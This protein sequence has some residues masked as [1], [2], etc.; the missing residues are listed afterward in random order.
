MNQRERMNDGTELVSFKL[1]YD[2]VLFILLW[3]LFNGKL[4]VE[5]LAKIIMHEDRTILCQKLMN[6]ELD[7]M[8][9]S[10]CF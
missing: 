4:N 7:S 2:E 9:N 8:M 5:D 6:D 1:S 10:L 3:K